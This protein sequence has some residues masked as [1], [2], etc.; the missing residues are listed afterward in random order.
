MTGQLK[1]K[2][3]CKKVAYCNE[4]CRLKDEKYHLQ[5]CDAENEV[6]FNKLNFVKS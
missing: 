3:A 4:S 2:C 5:N 6:D 1:S